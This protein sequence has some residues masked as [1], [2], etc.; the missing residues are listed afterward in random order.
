MPLL[1]S[2][3]ASAILLFIFEAVISRLAPGRVS[4]RVRQGELI[5]GAALLACLWHGFTKHQL[6]D[7][8]RRN[9]F[10]AGVS[11]DSPAALF[12]YTKL[13]E[14]IYLGRF[15]FADASAAVQ[16]SNFPEADKAQAFRLIYSF[17]RTVE[18]GLR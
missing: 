7:D 12:A 10:R 6:Q 3:I 16:G 18:P 13:E 5:V 9:F 15:C 8:M 17:S 11:E 4:K 2:V 14:C 1:S